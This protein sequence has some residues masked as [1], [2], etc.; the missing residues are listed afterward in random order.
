MLRQQRLSRK[1]AVRSMPFNA[2]SDLALAA[3]VVIF[4]MFPVGLVSGLMLMQVFGVW[5]R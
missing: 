3:T 5:S 1:A 4:G 2:G